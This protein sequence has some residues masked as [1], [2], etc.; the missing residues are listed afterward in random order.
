MSEITFI[1]KVISSLNFLFIIFGILGNLITFAVLS[2]QK[3]RKYSCMRY[4]AILCICDICCLFTWNFSIVYKELFRGK[5][6]EFEGPLICR[7]FSFYSYFI[8]QSSSWIICWIGM[9]RLITVLSKSS[10]I[11]HNFKNS[12]K[13]SAIILFTIFV[14]N[15]I[16]FFNNAPPYDPNDNNNITLYKYLNKN[17]FSTKTWEFYS[18]TRTFSCYEPSAFYHV[19]DIIHI[20][21][22]SIIPFIIILGE[23]IALSYLTIKYSKRV[24]MKNNPIT[25]ETSRQSIIALSSRTI[26]DMAIIEKLTRRFDK[27]KRIHRKAADLRS[28]KTQRNK[29]RDK[30]LYAG[31]ALN[32]KLN[33]I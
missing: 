2:R 27:K 14:F 23:N 7:I 4:L 1:K 11:N 16:V 24:N 8:L 25:L 29:N 31:Y 33:L 15:L 19:W 22:Y 5:K 9:D 10:K 30:I 17:I 20:F 28:L 21:F 32:K 26:K 12:I 6:I 13:I 18:S 3:I